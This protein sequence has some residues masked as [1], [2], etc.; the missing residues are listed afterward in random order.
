MSDAKKV[1]QNLDRI[2]AKRKV[3]IYALSV[4]Y[5]ARALEDFRKRQPDGIGVVGEFWTNQTT[6]AVKRVFTKAFQDADSVGWIIAHGVD[7]GVYLEKANDRQNEALRPIMLE[8]SKKYIEA[9]KGIM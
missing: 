5:A 2:F 3:L 4:E 6:D 9:I 7:Y 8:W 1:N